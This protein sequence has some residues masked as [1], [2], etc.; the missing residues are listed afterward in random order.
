MNDKQFAIAHD[1]YLHNYP[2]EWEYDGECE[3]DD[4]EL[5]ENCGKCHICDG[6]CK[7][8]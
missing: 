4:H 2:K 1:N 8:E 3:N 7:D 5:C 6:K